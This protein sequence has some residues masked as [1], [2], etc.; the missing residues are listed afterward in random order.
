[1]DSNESNIAPRE[2]LAIGKYA[3]V[4]ATSMKQANLEL[5]RWVAAAG[6]IVL[7]FE[8]WFYHKRTV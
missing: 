2:E 7:L 5:W 6:L 3:K 8:W 4:S 1:M